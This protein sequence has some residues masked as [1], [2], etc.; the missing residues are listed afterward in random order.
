MTMRAHNA[1]EQQLSM[2]AKQRYFNWFLGFFYNEKQHLSMHAKQHLSMRALVSISTKNSK[3]LCA[4]TALILLF[5]SLM[6][7]LFST[8]ISSTAKFSIELLFP[9]LALFARFRQAFLSI[10]VYTIKQ[11]MT[12]LLETALAT[13]FCVKHFF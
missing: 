2:R 5:F 1:I 4:Q 13:I 3:C 10:D 12:S 9:C 11:A 8:Q 7:F 6:K